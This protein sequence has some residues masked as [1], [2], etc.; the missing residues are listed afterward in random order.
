M[1][2]Y[3]LKDFYV[4]TP[5]HARTEM[6]DFTALSYFD[7]EKREGVLLTDEDTGESLEISGQQMKTQGMTL[8][9][10]DRRMSRLLW[11]RVLPQV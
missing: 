3:L 5:W 9:F 7:P 6:A 4:H 8:Y 1:K 10:R 11:V 2:P